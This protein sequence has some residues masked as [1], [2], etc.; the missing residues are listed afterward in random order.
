MVN[1]DMVPFLILLNSV[2]IFL[3]K[4]LGT[5]PG[6]QLK[7]YLWSIFNCL[8]LWETFTQIGQS[9]SLVQSATSS[10][11]DSNID[12]MRVVP[13]PKHCFV[14]ISRKQ[15]FLGQRDQKKYSVRG[16]KVPLK[17]YVSIKRI[18][19]NLVKSQ[20]EKPLRQYLYY[21]L[22]AALPGCEY[23]GEQRPHFH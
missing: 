11:V 22:M 15:K 4:L 19:R 3:L 10:T 7:S 5:R 13:I 8:H 14:Q 12:W 17:Y 23:R 20:L 18:R 6:Q 9:F 16:W 2:Y 21:P 1:R